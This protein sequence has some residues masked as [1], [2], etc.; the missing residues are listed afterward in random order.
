MDR[1]YAALARIQL[2][3]GVC[4]EALTIERLG[5]LTNASYKIINNSEAYVLR[6][7]GK[8]TCDYIDREAEEHNARITAA[9]G[10]SA[11][12]L[13]FDT[14][15]GTMLSRFIEGAC[16]N[17]NGFIRASLA[18][19]RAARVLRQ[20]HSFGPV[21]K[22][23]FNVFSM[24]DNYLG[25]LR[26]LGMPREAYYEVTQEV[27]QMRRALEASPVPLA[28]CHNDP[29]PGNFVDTGRDLYLIDWEFSG[30]NDPMWDLGDLS[31][32][33]GF[34]PEQDRMMLETYCNGNVPPVL[35]SRLTLYKV[36][37]DL[38]WALWGLI[39]DA[40]G[41]Q[42]DDFQAYTLRRLERCKTQMGSTG[43]GRHL[44]NVYAGNRSLAP[45]ACCQAHPKRKGSLTTRN[46]KLR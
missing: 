37:S 9:A 22:S 34:G 18:P 13:Y 14:K 8:D 35:Y 44:A 32:E 39:Q 40:N 38:L 5:S 17:G 24:M 11:E 36:M 41:N 4:S 29:W 23:R 16:T 21:F 46:G 15:D 30:M 25:I 6:L 1:V 7:P 3:E 43:F 33:A 10:V 12:V 45:R 26:K 2:L 31:V 28:P 42:A 27:A 20:V 19:A